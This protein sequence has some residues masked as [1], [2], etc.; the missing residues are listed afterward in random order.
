MLKFFTVLIS[1]TLAVA[2]WGLYNLFDSRDYN[3]EK[4]SRN[5]EVYVYETEVNDASEC[6]SYESFDADNGVCYFECSS[7]SDCARIENEISNELDSWA[8][9]LESENSIAHREENEEEES[10]IVRY[11]IKKDETI[12]Y[13]DGADQ[14]KYKEVWQEIKDLSPDTLS[15]NYLE[16]FEVFDD[17]SSDT[18]AFVDDVDNNNKW[19]IA[20]NYTSHKNENLKEQKATLIHELAHIISLNSSQIDNLNTNTNTNK[21]NNKNTYVCSSVYLFE[22]CANNQSYIYGFYRNFW[23][24]KDVEQEQKYSKDKFVSEY[25]STNLAE[26]FA[27][28]FTHFVLSRDISSE[29][30]VADKKIKYMSNYQELLNIRN[31]M[32]NSLSKDIIRTKKIVK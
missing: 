19:R 24:G 21:S 8:S 13:I 27:E 5:Q 30:N 17:P 4:E 3:Y 2:F 26:D 29:K 15:E 10:M 20:I 14:K 18:L 7:E 23:Q 28:S 12:V 16:T 6:S 32:R 31:E 22:G 9:E 25:A 1:V 11:Q